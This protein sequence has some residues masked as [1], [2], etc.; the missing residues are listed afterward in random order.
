VDANMNVRRAGNVAVAVLH[1]EYDLGNAAVLNAELV[2]V[3]RCRPAGIV[4]DV[5][6]VDF[7]D[8]A[9]LRSMANLGRRA[10]AVGIWVR[11][12]GPKP[13]LRRL[14]DVT[15]LGSSL[16]AYPDVELALRG[17]RRPPRVPGG[18]VTES[19]AV[20]ARTSAGA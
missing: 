14:L 3:L 7:C 18:R 16:P 4:L 5:A 11:I 17:S 6:E 8:L 13:M 9:C 15:G 20:D 2:D 10:A 1:G 12:A 19:L